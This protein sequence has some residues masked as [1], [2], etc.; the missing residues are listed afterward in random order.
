MV[1]K[2]IIFRSQLPNFKGKVVKLLRHRLNWSACLSV[3]DASL[4]LL[5]ST[6]R[7]AALSCRCLVF[8]TPHTDVVTGLCQDLPGLSSLF[9]GFIGCR[10]RSLLVLSVVLKHELRPAA[11]AGLL[12]CSLQTY[13]KK[14]NTLL[15]FLWMHVWM[16]FFCHHY[17]LTGVFTVRGNNMILSVNLR[18]WGFA[19]YID[20]FRY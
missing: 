19:S 14:K 20:K 18:N 4:R 6:K 8:L 2:K 11:E 3:N 1:K 9:W 17:Y 7:S 16:P 15:R 12:F 13:K 5:S 10:T